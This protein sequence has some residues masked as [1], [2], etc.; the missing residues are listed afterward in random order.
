MR[1]IRHQS[2]ATTYVRPAVGRRA[3]G[4]AVEAA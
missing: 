1:R 4:G 3:A 2:F